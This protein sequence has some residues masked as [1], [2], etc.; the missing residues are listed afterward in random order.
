MAFDRFKLP[1]VGKFIL[2]IRNTAVERFRTSHRSWLV[3]FIGI[4]EFKQRQFGMA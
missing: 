1:R 3:R 4:A 2:A